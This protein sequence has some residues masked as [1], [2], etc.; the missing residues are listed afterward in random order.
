MF[1]PKPGQKTVSLDAYEE[2]AVIEGL[3]KIRTEQ[4]EKA[5][6]AEFVSDLMLKIIRAPARKARIRD[7]AR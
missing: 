4:L 2:G 1:M 6:D 3:N 5:G 7:E